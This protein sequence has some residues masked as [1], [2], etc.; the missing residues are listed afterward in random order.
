MLRQSE[1]DRF[2]DIA[3]DKTD[4][5]QYDVA[6]RFGVHRSLSI[7]CVDDFDSLDMPQIGLVQDAYEL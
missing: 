5:D 1:N 6:R 7:L 4:N 3:T 2:R